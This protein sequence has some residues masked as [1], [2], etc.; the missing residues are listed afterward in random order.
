MFKTLDDYKNEKKEDKNKKTTNSYAGGQSSGINVENPDNNEEEDIIEKA[1]RTG[2]NNK[3]DFEK[4]ENKMKLTVYKNGF[5][6][7]DGEF[8]PI[9]DEKNKKFMEEVT[10]GYIPQEIVDQGKKNLAIAFEDKK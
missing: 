9:T 2:G 4:S 8:R 5:V 7:D 1:K 6:I 3:E 10:K